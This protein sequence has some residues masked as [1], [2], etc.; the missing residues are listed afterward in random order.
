MGE[1]QSAVAQRLGVSGQMVSD[2]FN[3]PLFQAEYQQQLAKI[4]DTHADYAAKCEDPV[5]A[6][7][8]KVKVEA[9]RENIRL[10]RNGES[11][12]IRQASAWDILDRAGY[13]PRDVVEQTT[14][15]VIDGKQAE[16]LRAALEDLG[17][18]ESES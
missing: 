6:E 5:R 12:R 10:M 13:K 15:V 1:S 4:M 9:M 3:S 17:K 7:L 11:E 8:D 16:G 18:I 2:L 14:R